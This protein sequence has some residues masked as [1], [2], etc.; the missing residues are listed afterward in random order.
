LIVRRWT[1]SGVLLARK[2]P[3]ALSGAALGEGA[4]SDPLRFT[5]NASPQIEEQF[6]DMG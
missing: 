2:Q 5:V 6:L 4:A 1:L 3:G